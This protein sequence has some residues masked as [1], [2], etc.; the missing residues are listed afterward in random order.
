MAKFV[1]KNCSI[2]VNSV[3]LSDHADSVTIESTF[4]VVEANSF[5][6]SNYKAKLQGLGDATITV[7]FLQDFAAGSVDATLWPLSQ[8]GATFPIVV[9]PVA[10]TVSATNPSYTMTAIL[11]S[12]NPL[13]GSIGD[14][15]GTDVSFENASTSGIVR[16]T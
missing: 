9:K 2:V 14:V 3:D 8:S 13:D 4:D 5:G 10:T 12:F 6:T 15:S 16:A 1:L 11:A 7:H